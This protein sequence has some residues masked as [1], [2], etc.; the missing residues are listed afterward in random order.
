MT[1]LIPKPQGELEAPLVFKK[2]VEWRVVVLPEEIPRYVVL[3]VTAPAH[4]VF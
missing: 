1:L 2:S 3:L 4:I